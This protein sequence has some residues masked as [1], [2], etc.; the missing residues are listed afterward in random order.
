MKNIYVTILLYLFANLTAFATHLQ[1]GEIRAR[2][3]S[4][5]TYE[6]SVLLYFDTV[7]GQ[8]SATQQTSI[9]LC[10]GD[11][12]NMTVSRLSLVPLAGVQGTS[13][14][15]YVTNHTYGSQGIYQISAQVDNRNSDILNF[16]NSQNTALFL[17]TVLHTTLPNS[18]PILPR[19]TFNAGV[20]QPFVVDLKATDVEGDSVSFVLQKLSKP[21]PGTCAVRS[22]DNSFIYP[23]EVNASGTFKIDQ[24]KKQL[25]WTAPTQVGQYVFAVVMYEWRD[26]V[27]ISEA[28]REGIINV[29]DRPGETV[30]IPPYENAENTGPITSVPGSNSP[31]IS[32]AV[33]AYPV[34]TDDFVTVKAYSKDP[35]IITLQVIDLQG[36]VLQ[37]YRAT[38]AD[39]NIEHQFDLRNY[40]SGVYMIRVSN[41]TESVSKKILR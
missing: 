35:A 25:V 40:T 33:D 19:L 17:W 21:S 23:N 39:R 13:I 9:N 34:P 18:T 41:D 7:G 32:I 3:L 27:R 30:E 2:Q 38:V 20:K 22:V 14:G 31:E 36:R 16:Q 26:G 12:Q 1:G 6:I 28:Y 10:T 8:G 15:T 5:Q 11:G 24:N 29:T 4:G 37:E